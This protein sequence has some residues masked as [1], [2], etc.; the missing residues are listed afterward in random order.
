MS[1]LAIDS[2][3]KLQMFL[4]YGVLA[5]AVL[6]LGIFLAA[7]L[8]F[9]AL[10]VAGVVGLA[11]LPYHAQLGARIAIATFGSALILPVARGGVSVWLL[12][13]IMG[14]SGVAVTLMVRRQSP[15]FG[16]TVRRNKWVYIGTLGFCVV[17]L[18]L[19][20]LKQIGFGSMGAS[21]QGARPFFENIISGIFPLLLVVI[22]MDEKTV[23]RLIVLQFVLVF[24]FVITDASIALGKF[25]WVFYFLQYSPDAFNFEQ[26]AEN[27]GI[28][29]FQSL[30]GIGTATATLLLLYNPLR[31]FVGQRAVWLIP[32]ML[33]AM[34]VGAVSGH[35]LVFIGL[36]FTVF[37]MA[38]AQRF[39]SLR[40]LLLVMGVMLPLLSYIYLFT[41]TL[42]LPAQRAL[43]VLP[44]L[45]VDALA[46]MDADNTYLV[47][48]E[49]F[50]TGWKMVPDY[51]W[52]GRGFPVYGAVLTTREHSFTATVSLL[53]AN[54]VFAVGPLAVMIDTGLPGFVFF[55][56][57][58]FGGSLVA[59]RILR[60]LWLHRYEDKFALASG[61]MAAGWFSFLINWTI[62]QA[63]EAAM[64]SSFML[65]CG[66][67]I[68]CERLL[69]RRTEH[70]LKETPDLA[71]ADH[72]S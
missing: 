62:I 50:K 11:T 29:R 39:F 56:L 24:T 37:L 40:N 30:A 34:A 61:A 21:N 64:L 9:I 31:S 2:R 23:F 67:L 33:A 28:R 69:R 5:V 44:G 51:L 6:L 63:G 36:G 57:M 71:L 42:P 10:M 54:G 15:A 48:M 13:G 65:P 53:A 14:W 35:R 3:L 52:I 25:E 58:L 22:E 55:M 17:L 7:D 46:Q 43:S 20:R 60:L 12:A 70:G 47:R 32:V 72:G 26:A 19:M 59:G 16:E 41:D 1:T 45:K 49:L 66:V 4:W 68:L 38:L 8:Y 18:A 27:F